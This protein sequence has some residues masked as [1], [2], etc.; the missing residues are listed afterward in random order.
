MRKKDVANALRILEKNKINAHVCI[1][2]AAEYY[3]FDGEQF[4]DHQLET[5]EC[6]CGGE[7]IYKRD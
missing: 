2:C 3:I 7:L 1:L 4:A 5:G 6:F